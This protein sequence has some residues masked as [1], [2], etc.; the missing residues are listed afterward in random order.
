MLRTRVTIIAGF[1]GAGKTTLLNTL[2]RETTEPLGV[3]VNDFGDVNIDAELVTGQTSVDGEVALHN[4]CICCTIRGDLLSAVL[5]LIRRPKPT[6]HVL[7]EASGV[8]DPAAIARTFADPR[9]ADLVELSAV[10]GCVDPTE[11]PALVGQ[12]WSLATTQL[13][14]C[15]FVV[16]TKADASSDG[17]RNAASALVRTLSPRARILQSSLRGAPTALLLGA[18]GLWA[19]DRMAGARPGSRPAHVHRAGGGGHGHHHDQHA[20]FFETWTYRTTAPLSAVSLRA[21]LKR[22]PHALVRAKGF[23]HIGEAPQVRLLVQVVASRV[24]FRH[25][26]SAWQGA[27]QTELVFLGREGGLDVQDLART[28][29]ACRY[30]PLSPGQPYIDEMLGHFSRV[31]S[32]A[33]NH[34]G[35]R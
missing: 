6:R 4:G 33:P 12:D 29:D 11:F 21:I 34:R 8:S 1:L 2:L 16:L 17:E 7:I 31:L 23:A 15:D 9:L 27:P 18:T 20:P 5:S 32:T 28:L 14:A 30:D 24:E 13:Q 19:P 10:I 26:G 22:L 35:R 25:H 3:I